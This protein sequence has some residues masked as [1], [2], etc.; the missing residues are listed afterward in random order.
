M[1]LIRSGVVIALSFLLFLSVF[2]GNIFL[3][4]SW[5]LEYEN[6]EP[7][8]SEFGASIVDDSGVS[9]MLENDYPLMM[10]YCNSNSGNYNFS[11]GGLILDIP[12]SEV[13]VGPENVVQYGV[14]KIVE[15]FYY[16]EYDCSF[17]ECLKNEGQPY[18][19][20]S[21]KARSYFNSNFNWILMVSIVL[22]ILL[23]LFV[24]S[25]GTAF[26]ISGILISFAALP[27]RKFNW[28]LS[29]LP[30]GNVSEFFLA[31]FTKSYNVFMIMI[32]IGIAL[33]IMGISFHF[34][35]WGIKMSEF[36]RKHLDS[37]VSKGIDQNKK[38]E[39][40][41]SE[42]SEREEISKI[43]EETLKLRKEALELKE[44]A[45]KLIKKK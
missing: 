6:V 34:L 23:F 1:G 27:F 10:D 26:I 17:F 19:L 41:F 32:I 14:D 18:V 30:K 15:N 4:L 12:C 3:T 36:F 44:E 39:V 11:G 5:S 25:K 21:E 31:F 24:E 37:K 29:F 13:S 7:L 38:G 28:I 9:R 20:I 35:G 43:K 45:M 40:S 8:V 22:F 33:L 42:S 16:R 2:V